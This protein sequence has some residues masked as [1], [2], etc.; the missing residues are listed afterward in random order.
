[1]HRWTKSG[2]P[3]VGQIPED[4]EAGTLRIYGGGDLTMRILP[5]LEGSAGVRILPNGEI[6]VRGKIAVPEPV[7]LFKE[8]R[9]D[10]EILGLISISRFLVFRCSANVSASLSLLVAS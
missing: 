2:K 7:E 6:E 1:M 3:I 4:T 9:W 10:K 5:W 8:K